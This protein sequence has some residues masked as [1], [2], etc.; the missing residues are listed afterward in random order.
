MNP[1]K[2]SNPWQTWFQIKGVSVFWEGQLIKLLLCIELAK[3]SQ[4][5]AHQTC[6]VQTLFRPV[7]TSGLLMKS[8]SEELAEAW[9]PIYQKALDLHPVPTIWNNLFLNTKLEENSDYCPVTL[10][11][12][13]MKCFE[14]IVIKIVKTEVSCSLDTLQFLYRCNM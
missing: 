9:C 2:R 12:V 11:S 4:K 8:F 6:V 3:W 5:S 14:E 13:V 1:K 10:I 7:T